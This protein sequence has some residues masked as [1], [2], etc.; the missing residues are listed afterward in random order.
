MA[1]CRSCHK[2]V[3]GRIK[4]GPLKN[5]VLLASDEHRQAHGFVEG[6]R[7]LADGEDPFVP[8]PKIVPV[9]INKKRRRKRNG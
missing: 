2:T 1:G 6:I 5:C 3:M 8:Y 7:G 9:R 4:S